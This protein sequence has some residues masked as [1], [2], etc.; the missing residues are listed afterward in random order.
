MSTR[1]VLATDL[2]L[3]EL[4]QALWRRAKG[5]YA[6]EASVLLLAFHD[7]WLR[8]PR[9]VRHITL[10]SD[11]VEELDGR[12]AAVAWEQIIGRDGL[13]R[14][15]DLY[16]SSSAVTV[17]RFAASLEGAHQIDV[18]D[19]IASLDDSNLRLVLAALSHAARGFDRPGPVSW[20]TR[21]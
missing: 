1:E 4:E 20:P 14:D 5:L 17:L 11:N 19:G 9:F 21:P 10:D 8:N 13:L 15:E 18:A 16:G 7:T 2:N 3:P 12:Y 6:S